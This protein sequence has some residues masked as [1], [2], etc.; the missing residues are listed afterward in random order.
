MRSH[1]QTVTKPCNDISRRDVLRRITAA[2]AFA[3]FPQSILMAAGVADEYVGL[4]SSR[5]LSDLKVLAKIENS[6]VFTEG[7]AADAHGNLYFTNV[8]ANRILKWDGTSLTVF[9]E[10][11]NAANGL[12]FEPDG[13]LLACEGGV[14]RVTRTNMKSGEV[15]VLADSY[16]GFPLASPNDLCCDASGRIYFTSRPGG[17]D[18]T[19]G[20]VNAVY[21]ID[22]DRTLTQLLKWPDIHMPNGIVISP[23]NRTLYL[24]EAHPEADRNRNILAFNLLP[25]G[26]LSNRRTLIDF[27]PGRSGDG[28][29][30]DSQGNLYV[31]AGLHATRKTSETLDTKPGI[32]VVSPQGKLLAFMETPEDTITN[33]TFG[34]SDLK[35]LFVACGTL[36]VSI[37]TK[38]PGKDNY[39]P[40]Q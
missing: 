3:A 6:K 15:T 7:P 5:Y 20:N 8:A 18:P 1:L 34:G 37:R 25:D 35:T 12:Y 10:N 26:S 39:R 32:H 38:I 30:I 19:K 17:E 13:S 2:G 31:A 11:S 40:R 21:R 33:C 29:C 22:S 9:R 27:Y 23:D 14:G 28:M 4:D 16:N 36:L 24:I